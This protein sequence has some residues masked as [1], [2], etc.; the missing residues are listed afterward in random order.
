VSKLVV[1]IATEFIDRS[2]WSKFNHVAEVGWIA[3]EGGVARFL[4]S[5]ST[6]YMDV[7]AGLEASTEPLGDE[8]QT[9]I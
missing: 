9:K 3:P 4:R 2:H 1:S 5:S 6:T 7:S 8:I